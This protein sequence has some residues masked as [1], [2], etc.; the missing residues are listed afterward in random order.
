M[1]NAS[2]ACN[3]D[4]LK[5]SPVWESLPSIGLQPTDE[6]PLELRNCDRCHTTLAR[7]VR[8]TARAIA[9]VVSRDSRPAVHFAPPEGDVTALRDELEERYALHSWTARGW[10]ADDARRVDR[11]VVSSVEC[12]A[13]TVARR[14]ES[15][16]ERS[17]A[18]HGEWLTLG[19]ESS[20]GR[21]V[22]ADQRVDRAIAA[23][24]G[25]R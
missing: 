4:A 8:T 25:T 15:E 20:L 22:A 13:W 17:E 5:V 19:R 18:E 9:D 21:R 10:D 1:H 7:P 24:E 16:A 23:I 11:L 12:A 6:L 2:T 14:I 3:H